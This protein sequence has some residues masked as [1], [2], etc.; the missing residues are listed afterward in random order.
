MPNCT[1]MLL[2]GF[3]C[4]VCTSVMGATI[5][6]AGGKNHVAHGIKIEGEI[7]PGDALKFLKM[8]EYFG[9][10]AVF[11]RSRGGNVEEAMK[12]GRLIRR[13]RLE[14]NAPDSSEKRLGVVEGVPDDANN[15]V[16]A[17]AC[18]LIY[19]AGVTRYGDYLNLHRAAPPRDLG[20]TLTDVEYESLERA[21]I[22]YVRGYLT[23]MEL[24]HY[25]I[26]KTIDTN[27]QNGYS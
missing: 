22:E 16:C 26:E 25:Y 9:P 17:S 24:D 15:I 5:E 19:A 7:E 20:A 4:S 11:L 6:V 2:V 13:F 12:I 23:E 8:Y 18:V 1:Q 27:S 3:I 14:T 10:Q 21:L